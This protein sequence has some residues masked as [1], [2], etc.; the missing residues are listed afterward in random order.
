MTSRS[1]VGGLEVL[2]PLSPKEERALFPVIARGREAAVELAQPRLDPTVK[3]RLR[4]ERAE[5]ERAEWIVIRSTCGLVARRVRERGF[6]FD[7]EELEAAGVEG[8]IHAMH[9]FDPE[10]G[11]RF[12]TYASYWINKMVHQAVRQQA[13]LTEAE[14]ANIL[15]LQ[16]LR[17]SDVDKKFSTKEIASALGVSIAKAREIQ[18]LNDDFINLRFVDDSHPRVEQRLVPEVVDAPKWV[19]GALRRLCGKDF[20]AFWQY[21]FKTMTIEEIA[22]SR[23]ISRQAMTKRLHKCRAAVLSSPDAERLQ[24]WFARQ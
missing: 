6:H 12:V 10:K 3:R 14:M 18:Q 4:R 22:A 16:K 21:V 17:R 1:T 23:G 11:V 19:I 15:A 20:D 7:K 5:G 8:L 13:G 2:Q 24:R 9:R